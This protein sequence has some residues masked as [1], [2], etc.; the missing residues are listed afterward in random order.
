[1]QLKG[2]TFSSGFVHV[3]KDRIDLA[4]AALQQLQKYGLA[5]VHSMVAVT[6]SRVVSSPL[7]FSLYFLIQSSKQRFF[8]S[9]LCCDPQVTAPGPTGLHSPARNLFS[10][11]QTQ[12]SF[13]KCGIP[14]NSRNLPSLVR[15][16][17]GWRRVAPVNQTG[18]KI[19]M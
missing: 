10:P 15:H 1:M 3:A 13:N 14:A 5:N 2:K 11:C 12:V 17:P 9:Q 19:N 18:T 7:S 4:L 6:W 16:I 8:S